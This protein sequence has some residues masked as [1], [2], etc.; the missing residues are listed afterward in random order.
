MRFRMAKKNSNQS[1]NLL[2]SRLQRTKHDGKGGRYAQQAEINIVVPEDVFPAETP[3]QGKNGSTAQHDNPVLGVQDIYGNG[4][5]QTSVQQNRVTNPYQSI[6]N[7][8]I[9]QDTVGYPLQHGY[10]DASPVIDTAS[11]DFGQNT[12][13]YSSTQSSTLAGRIRQNMNDKPNTPVSNVQEFAVDASNFGE[14]DAVNIDSGSTSNIPVV[15]PVRPRREPKQ[16]KNKQ[17][18]IP[19]S[20]RILDGKDGNPFKKKLPLWTKI[21]AILSIVALLIGIPQLIFRIPA[22]M[23]PRDIEPQLL[24]DTSGQKAIIDYIK[25]QHGMEDWDKDG[26]TNSVDDDIYNPDNNGDGHPDGMQSSGSIN[27]GDIISYNNVTI[28]VTNT[29]VG[30]SKF[31]NYYVFVNHEGWVKISGETGI[32]YIYDKKGWSEA[33]YKNEYGDYII[34]I[35]HDCYLEF[36]PEGTTKV[37]RTDFLGN[38]SFASKE[39]RYVKNYGAF[40]G[41]ASVLLHSFLPVTEPTDN[42]LASIWYSDTYHIVKQNNVTKAD[43]VA[44]DTSLYDIS[45]MKDY[46]FT[47]ERLYEVYDKIDNQETVLIS[48]LTPDGGEAT[49]F[50]YAYDYLGNFYV[51]DARTSKTAGMIHVIPKAQIY[52]K[53]G[54]KYIRE[55]YEFEGLGFS[56]KQDDNLFIY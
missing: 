16:P 11:S 54:A 49:C 33:E 28:E 50:I 15:E 55:W 18:K 26:L 48:I 47:Y 30:F 23:K 2:S 37:Y 42:T 39:S 56:S 19:A 17:P 27:I 5:P 14:N 7:Q 53:D 1:E 8:T 6:P 13:P 45:I 9:S 21:V 44:P 4:V 35:P 41:I 29:K 12:S 51:A 3:L 32:P 22:A 10:G 52:I 24:I 46:A 43:A 36:V 40:S 20:E 25:V 31:M 34:Y 38:K